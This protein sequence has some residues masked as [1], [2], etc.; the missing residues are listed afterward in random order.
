MISCEMMGRLG[1]QMFIAATAYSLALD[2]DDEVVFPRFIS[3]II[4]TIKETSIHRGTIFRNLKY[5]DDLSF[6]NR[7]HIHSEPQDHSYAE[8]PYKTN[9]FLHGYFQSEK[10]FKHNRQEILN[11]FKPQE[12]IERYLLKKY[13]NLIE[14]KKCVSVHIRRGDDIEWCKQTFEGDNNVFVEKQDDVLDL[15]LMSKITNNIIANSS[16]SWW[17]AW[18]NENKDKTV[19]SPK[20]WFGPRNQHLNRRDTTPEGWVII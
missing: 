19:I 3:G 9:M 5:V 14:N 18:L 12:Q 6:V 11:L 10:Y 1:N 2:N 20:E 4:P 16:F 13:S 17:A 15:Y 7:K 8:I